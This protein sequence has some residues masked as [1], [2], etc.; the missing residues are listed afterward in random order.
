[1]AVTS[2]INWILRAFQFLFGVVILGL[3]VTL[4]RGHHWGSLPSSLGY[5]AFLGGI[6]ILAALIGF[7]GTWV[8]F[9]EGIVGAVFDTLVAIVNIAGGIVRLSYLAPSQKQLHT[10]L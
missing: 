10:I 2:L 6:S 3:S 8:T 5:G 7:A 4:I 9:L 1:M